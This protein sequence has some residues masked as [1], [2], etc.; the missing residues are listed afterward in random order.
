MSA[1]LLIGGVSYTFVENNSGDDSG[2]DQTNMVDE[3]QRLLLDVI[4]YTG[5]AHFVYGEQVT[6][7]DPV[8]GIIFSGII[9]TD[10]EV[11][12]YPSGVIRHSI[13]CI[14]LSYFAGKRTYTRTYDTPTFAGKIMVDH[15][16]D[17]L[18]AEGITQSYALHADLTDVD[19][20]QGILSGTVD[21]LNVGDGDLELTPAGSNVTII[22]T[23]T[24][25]FATGTLT[26]VTATNNTLVPTTVSGFQLSALLPVS[27]STAYLNILF[28][29][30]SKALGTND[31]L[32]YDIWI[33]STSP[34][35]MGA[36]YFLF[37]DGTTSGGLV[38][39][40]GVAATSA[41][42]L[43]NYAKDQWYSRGC[44]TSTWNGK[45][46]QNVIF[47]FGGTSQG[48]YT[49]YLKNV[50]LS[51]SPGSP[52][53]GTT[54]TSIQLNPPVV[55]TYLWYLPS[56]IVASVLQVMNPATTSRVSPSH[57][58]DAVKL[59]S[60]STVVWSATT[61]NNS[62]CILKVSYDG[63]NS[64]ALCTNNSALPALPAGSN[65]AGLSIILQ[66]SFTAGTDPSTL[67][68]LRDVAMTLVSAPHA[69]K[70][71]IVQNYITQSDWNTGTYTYLTSTA[72]GD[73]TM[74]TLAR[75]WNDN[76][77]TNQTAFFPDGNTTQSAASGAYAM[78]CTTLG[79]TGTGYGTS[80][81]DFCGLAILNFTLDIDMKMSTT[82]GDI[83]V[84]FRTTS[85][86]TENN[87]FAYLVTFGNN[88]MSLYVG[89]N[90]SPG[91]I[92]TLATAAHTIN[93][94]TFYHLKLVV[95]G[96]RFQCYFNN[97]GTPS[98]DFTDT[99]YM[100]QQP[101]GIGLRQFNHTSGTTTTTWDNLAFAPS[102]FG[103]WQSSAVSLASLGTCGLSS[104]FWTQLNAINPQV[105][106]ALIQTSVDGGST[107]QTCTNN[108]GIPNLP[109]GTNV[110]SISVIVKI[111]LS[112]ISFDVTPIIRQLVW[113]VLGAYPGSSGTRS[114]IPLGNDTMLR[115]NSSGN[116]G[117][118]FDSQT[119]TKTGTGTV[120]LNSNEGQIINT[121]GDVHMQ[122][123]SRTW[124]DEEGTV[125]FQLSASTISGGLELRY[126]DANNYYRLSA[127]T[128]ALAIIQNRSGVLTTLAT[129]AVTLSTGTWYRM[130]F[131]C[132]GNGP[133]LMYGRVWL[134]GV[135]EPTTWGVTVSV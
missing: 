19:F 48:T 40:N 114:T 132:I 80:R 47:K 75:N 67:P 89:A 96:L 26:N 99:A 88:S 93:A 101:G 97:E 63:G 117:T 45:T 133:V 62:S 108:G 121:T 8:L 9:N 68:I 24:A 4:D 28:W 87:T 82:V 52:F 44:S 73:L 129:T 58:I 106:Y 34:Q 1:T 66:E 56:S 100:Y 57:S 95:T 109:S 53:F 86:S 84:S 20:N 60:S 32:N 37:T 85:W 125:R 30:G 72:G 27:Q 83:G 90:G 10:K 69:T 6:L 46:I 105:S 104:I 116:W 51:S 112:S 42:D 118:A 113:R 70:S 119:Y 126:V 33:A 115:S 41:I 3:R 2:V 123:G 61:L 111:F 134:D 35:I 71:D 12:K 7:T 103:T 39:Q 43:S 94:N 110:S 74:G 59:L 98:I 29:S 5:S 107:F 78:T 76:L 38:D 36:V 91:G 13:D 92:T 18:A 130:R 17:V 49:A 79:A 65:V 55:W 14:D 54:A 16:H 64:Y 22:E 127:S 135:L 11:N 122:L 81:L 124:T 120:N 131:R 128:T 21:T 50:Y 31:T 23:T 102:P 15:L 77:I 25:D